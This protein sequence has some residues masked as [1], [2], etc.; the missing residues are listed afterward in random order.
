MN[1]KNTRH[2]KRHK[3]QRHWSR[4]VRNQKGGQTRRTQNKTKVM[5]NPSEYYCNFMKVKKS[6]TDVIHNHE[7]IRP[8]IYE[9]C[10]HVSKDLTRR[11][12]RDSSGRNP[13][14]L[15][16]HR[17][18]LRPKY[19]T[20]EHK[21]FRELLSAMNQVHPNQEEMRQIANKL[22]E[23]VK[24]PE[25]ALGRI[26]LDEQ[27]KILRQFYRFYLK[28]G[29]AMHKVLDY[30]KKPILA[31]IKEHNPHGKDDFYPTKQEMLKLMGD[32][33]DYDFNFVIHPQLSNEDFHKIRNLATEYI[34]AY[35]VHQVQTH[36]LFRNHKLRNRIIHELSRLD[37]PIH[38]MKNQMP[39]NNGFI[40]QRISEVMEAVGYPA[41]SRVLKTVPNTTTSENKNILGETSISYVDIP[42]SIRKR[43]SG[44]RNTQFVLLRLMTSMKMNDRHS[45]K[46]QTCEASSINVAGELI[47]VSIPLYDSYEKFSKWLETEQVM[48]MDGIYVYNLY[49]MIHDLEVVIQE[50][51]ENEKVDKL[52]KRQRRLAFLHHLACIVPQYIHGVKSEEVKKACVNVLEGICQIGEDEM[53]EMNRDNLQMKLVGMYGNF[54]EVIRRERLNIGVV[55]KQ[56][57][58]YHL[59]QTYRRE[60]IPKAEMREVY[61]PFVKVNQW[62]DLEA[63]SMFGYTPS[64]YLMF[65]L[66]N[67]RAKNITHV[68]PAQS[69]VYMYVVA[70]IDALSRRASELPAMVQ[71]NLKMLLCKLLVEYNDIMVSINDNTAIQEMVIEFARSI[72]MI[73]YMIERGD[74]LVNF[75]NPMT[76]TVGT[77]LMNVRNRVYHGIQYKQQMNKKFVRE[78]H[79]GIMGIILQCGQMCEQ[80]VD[81]MTLRGSGESMRRR[82]ALTMRGGYLYDYYERVRQYV[83][84]GGGT[85]RRDNFDPS[86]D[87]QTNDIDT[88]IEL[89]V[90]SSEFVEI[91]DRIKSFLVLYFTRYFAVKSPKQRVM[92]VMLP[93]TDN[94]VIFQL[95]TYD[96]VAYPEVRHEILENALLSAYPEVRDIRQMSKLYRTFESHILE[97][98]VRNHPTEKAYQEEMSRHTQLEKLKDYAYTVNGRIE[99]PWSSMFTNLNAQMNRELNTIRIPPELSVL[100]LKQVDIGKL[101]AQSWMAMSEEYKE[102]TNGEKNAVHKV[103]Y[104][105]RLLSRRDDGMSGEIQYIV[106]DRLG[107]SPLVLSVPDQTIDYRDRR[108]IGGMEEEDDDEDGEQQG[109]R[110]M[111]VSRRAVG[112]MEEEED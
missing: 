57:F 103:K 112:A 5:E 86:R 29:S 54:P 73:Y 55:L 80:Y 110:F 81:K 88:G 58:Y 35:L 100:R 89:R 92:V 39:R 37:N 21:E 9:F 51:R 17:D 85:R 7:A 10:E 3:K 38:V 52:E 84:G 98:V 48:M 59:V 46:K 101:H 2:L 31:L 28:G 4:K 63:Q 23:F 78:H 41:D 76:Y 90:S 11:L 27:D 75:G 25:E 70:L 24:T 22:V 1:G 45:N 60:S 62:S 82:S 15:L 72:L 6:V 68:Y 95:I 30:L 79:V 111:S 96:Y 26:P 12:Y 69:A 61:S 40:S 107:G 44:Y 42:P 108:A 99:K 65:A 8:K 93:Q 36:P 74:M 56:Y 16:I 32:Y 64:Y 43:K 18:I 97:L 71:D 94:F 87:I 77:E 66:N 109:M 33:S 106:R 34:Y 91:C 67:T 105:D 53:T 13:F 104:I 50:T 49:S 19:E 14:L 47:D 102:I 83:S 20:P